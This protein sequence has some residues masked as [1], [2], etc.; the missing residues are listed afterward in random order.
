MR[1]DDVSRLTA[2]AVVR[3]VALL[4]VHTSPLAQPGTGDAGA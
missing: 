1:P 3:R 2:D 4:A